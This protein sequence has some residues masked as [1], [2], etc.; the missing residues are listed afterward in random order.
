MLVFVLK[1]SSHVT[2]GSSDKRD[3]GSVNVRVLLL[4]KKRNK[5]TELIEFVGHVRGAFVSDADVFKWQRVLCRLQCVE[6]RLS[7]FMYAESV[8]ALLAQSGTALLLQNPVRD[9]KVAVKEL[10]QTSRCRTPPVTLNY[11]PN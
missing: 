7:L 4:G 11:T 1:L 2:N 6:S 5:E 10:C 9:K 8:A 3:A